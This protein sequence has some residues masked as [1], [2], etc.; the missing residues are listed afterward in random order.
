MVAPYL[1]ASLFVS[2]IQVEDLERLLDAP[3]HV[4][5]LKQLSLVRERSFKTF[6]EALAAVDASEFDAMMKADAQFRS[7]AEAA[8]RQS[9]EWTYS[10][11]MAS[12]KASLVE[13]AAR[14]RKVAEVQVQANKQNQQAMQFLQMQQQQMQAIQQ[15]VSVS[16]RPF[17][18]IHTDQPITNQSF[19]IVSFFNYQGQS[20][21]WNIG[22]AYRVPDSNINLSGTYSQ[23]KGNLQISCVP[24]ESMSLLGPNGESL[25]FVFCYLFVVDGFMTVLYPLFRFCA[26]RDS[27]KPWYF[28][29]HQHLN[30]RWIVNVQFCLLGSY[31]FPCH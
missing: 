19:F 14:S 15:Q 3:L 20:S 11:E 26:R 13:M 9:P 31:T 24:D 1:H 10:K 12:L 22:M 7:E 30:Y 18:H 23:G 2:T 5:Y 28:V 17:S 8:T 4:L 21:P 6:K 25:H 27:W 29:Q 16:P